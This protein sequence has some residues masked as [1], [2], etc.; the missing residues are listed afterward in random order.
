MT[1]HKIGNQSITLFTARKI[2][3]IFGTGLDF[4]QSLFL[5]LSGLVVFPFLLLGILLIRSSHNL[6]RFNSTRGNIKEVVTREVIDVVEERA[7]PAFHVSNRN[8]VE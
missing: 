5:R 6:C 1:H 4:S 8:R 7:K 2:G 3:F